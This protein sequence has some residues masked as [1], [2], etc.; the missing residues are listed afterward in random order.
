MPAAAMICSLFMVYA[1][2]MAHG[3]SA[4]WYLLVYVCI[5]AVGLA[6]KDEAYQHLNQLEQI[7]SEEG[8]YMTDP[9]KLAGDA[10]Q[11]RRGT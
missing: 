10:Q 11:E 9:H 5:M 7:W 8:V 4:A 1:A 3:V 2:A 6:R